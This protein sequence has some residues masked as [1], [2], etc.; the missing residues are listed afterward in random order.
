VFSF[1]QENDVSTVNGLQGKI[2]EIVDKYSS[3]RDNLKYYDERIETLESHITQDAVYL[4]HK[5]VYE[6][7]QELKPRKQP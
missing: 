6:A 7:Y 4:K 3:A 1:M 5:N 2:K